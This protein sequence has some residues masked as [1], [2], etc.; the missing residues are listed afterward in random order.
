MTVFG[1]LLIQGL[2][3]DGRNVTS[4]ST[5]TISI[6]RLMAHLPY[7]VHADLSFSDLQFYDIIGTI[8]GE[9]GDLNV[10]K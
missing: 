7:S 4:P 1:G 3:E 5:R 6:L 10:F 9:D 2:C 8:I